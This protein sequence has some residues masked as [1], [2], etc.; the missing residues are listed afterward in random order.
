MKTPATL[1]T[2]LLA[3]VLHP[4]VQSRAH[5]ELDALL[6]SPLSSSGGIHRLPTAKDR[7]QLPFVDAIVKE[8]WRWN[9]SVPL[10]ACFYF[11]LCNRELV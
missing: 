2:F 7:S 4:E 11:V 8:V 9:P 5:A 10:G 3:M 1:V 6:G